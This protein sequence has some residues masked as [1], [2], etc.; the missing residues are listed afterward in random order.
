MTTTTIVGKPTPSAASSLDAEN[1]LLRA[2][3]RVDQQ[4]QVPE[5]VVSDRVLQPMDTH[6]SPERT[7]PL[8]ETLTGTSSVLK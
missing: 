7:I 6:E 3:Q 4:V 2:L 8:W 1:P 5:D